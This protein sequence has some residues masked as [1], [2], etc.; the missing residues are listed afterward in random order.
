MNLNGSSIGQVKSSQRK[1]LILFMFIPTVTL[2]WFVLYP[3]VKLIY[4]SFTNWD[5]IKSS[6]DFIGLSN[7]IRLFG[8]PDLWNALKNNAL[9]FFIHLL[10]IPI[11]LYV[12]FALNFYIKKSGIYKSVFFMPSIINGVAVSYMFSFIFSSQNGFLNAIL[13]VFGLKSVAWLS[14]PIIVRYSMV[15]VS[16]WMHTGMTTMLFLAGMQ[17]L[18][19]DMLESATVDGAGLFTQFVTMIIPNMT[20]VISLVMF[21]NARGALMQF[22]IPFVMT[23]GGPNGASTTY[24]LYLIN[25]AFQ[26]SNFGLASA[27]AITLIII[28]AILVLIQNLFLKRFKD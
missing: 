28:I 10:V 26:F 5:G 21:L 18:P 2:V 25:T 24:S 9:Y 3:M 15:M 20:T 17:S 7:Y 13:N 27:M 4:I 22:E 11:S 16:L 14:D 12:A 19:K 6:Y 1:L 23:S 8:I